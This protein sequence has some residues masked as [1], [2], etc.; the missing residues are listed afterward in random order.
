MSAA[1]GR[2]ARRRAQ[3]NLRTFKSSLCRNSASARERDRGDHPADALTWDTFTLANSTLVCGAETQ[4]L[5][6]ENYSASPIFAIYVNGKLVNYTV[7]PSIP[8]GQAVVNGTRWLIC[9]ATPIYLNEIVAASS[10]VTL[11]LFSSTPVTVFVVNSGPDISVGP[12]F[13]TRAASFPG[14]GRAVL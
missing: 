5:P 12:C 9:Q 6:S 2:V 8:A 10:N 7:T 11:A 13:D 3:H 14:L 1:S 4:F